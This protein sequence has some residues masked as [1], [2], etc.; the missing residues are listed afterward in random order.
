MSEEREYRPPTAKTQQRL[1]QALEPYITE[2][3]D[4]LTEGEADLIGNLHESEA[5]AML[6]IWLSDRVAL[7]STR[8]KEE[9]QKRQVAEAA[10]REVVKDLEQAERKLE[11]TE[12]ELQMLK[13][14]LEKM[15]VE[16]TTKAE[17]VFLKW[18]AGV[19]T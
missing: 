18:M 19:G 8:W 15:R 11:K 12:N 6:A 9:W 3:S 7:Y 17:N 5:T 1:N 16:Q 2:W 13:L 10:V 14:A 4:S